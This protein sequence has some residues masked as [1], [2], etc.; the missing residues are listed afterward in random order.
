MGYLMMMHM[1][2][3][4]ES[5]TRVLP[6]DCFLTKVFKN[7][8]VD[9]SRETDFETPTIYDTYDEQSL[10]RMKFEK[11]PNGSG[12]KRAKRPLPQAWGQG[13][14]HLGV[15]EEAEIREMDCGLD[16]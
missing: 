11:A 8:R 1:I 14:M 10:R 7:V 9:L 6:Y 12:I 15:E 2:S 3:C 5:M 4:C 13:Q 16:P